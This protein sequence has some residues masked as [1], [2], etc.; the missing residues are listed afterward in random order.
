MDKN[1][2][3]EIKKL[4]AQDRKASNEAERK[5]IDD[6]M[7]KLL[8]QHPEA[9]TEALDTLIDETIS[10]LYR[11]RLMEQASSPHT[12]LLSH[13]RY[14]K[15]ETEAPF[16]ESIPCYLWTIERSWI[17]RETT[18]AETGALSPKSTGI[19]RE[20]LRAGLYDFEKTDGVPTGLKAALYL[21]L[22]HW[23]EGMAT[24][25]TWER[26]YHDWKEARY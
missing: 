10:E 7:K 4:A 2:Y 21:L 13:C 17:E 6:T 24:T 20:Y 11:Y 9:C 1:I 19:I 15:G 23:N 14:Y 22:Q 3:N 5:A 8:S 12:S 25:E 26:F 16:T 18:D